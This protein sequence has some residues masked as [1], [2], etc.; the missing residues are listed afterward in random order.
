MRCKR[1]IGCAQATLLH[2]KIKC[3]NN[4]FGVFLVALVGQGAPKVSVVVLFSFC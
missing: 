4:F 2:L 3:F 1:C